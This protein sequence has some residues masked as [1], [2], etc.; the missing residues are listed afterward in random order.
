MRSTEGAYNSL[1]LCMGVYR[2]IDTFN[3]HPLYKQDG[4][5]H[6]LYYH[7]S[8]E[9]WMVG[10]QVGRNYGWIRNAEKGQKQGRLL[11]QDLQSGWQYQPLTCEGGE[12]NSKW[13]SDDHTLKVEPLRGKIK[14]TVLTMHEHS[15]KLIQYPGV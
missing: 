7:K 15:L 9:A 13:M 12:G 6:Y 14:L 5:E 3:D 2:L 1:P 10:P 4:G 8:L 11:P